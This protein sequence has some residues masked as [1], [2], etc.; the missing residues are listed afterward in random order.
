MKK[1]LLISLFCV[2]AFLT[3]HSQ[4]FT[5]GLGIS[6]LH[7]E[8]NYSG[9]NPYIGIA[10]TPGVTFLE[11]RKYALS[12]TAPLRVGYASTYFSQNSNDTIVIDDWQ[13]VIV[14]LPVLFNFA[15][16]AGSSQKAPAR[17]GFF[18][19]VGYGVQLRY[20]HEVYQ[21]NETK[22]I[23]TSSPFSTGAAFS[24]GIRLAVGR[25][26]RRKNIELG[27]GYLLGITGEDHNIISYHVLFNF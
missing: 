16:G 2:T 24:A 22:S 27:A 11:T 12:I 1:S 14:Q 5:N 9:N 10:Y 8:T 25:T 23:G 13:S 18:G 21:F 26:Y 4:H 7:D 6:I 3:C 20:Y 19:G 17:F 15:Y